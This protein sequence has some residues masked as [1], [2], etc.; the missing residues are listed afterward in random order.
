MKLC[1]ICQSK[2]PDDANFCP[3][4]SCA[5]AEG[6]RRL[7]A[8]PAPVAA[9]FQN[10]SK[11]GGGSTGEVWLA[12]DNESGIDVAY[13]LVATEALPTAATVAR[14]EREFKQLQRV[15]SPRIAAILDCGR[16]AEER[17]YVALELC[18]GDSL[19]RILKGGAVSLDKAKSI[20][21][22][23]GQALLEAQKAGIVHRDVAPKNVLVSSTGE[24]KVINFPLA[25]PLSDKIAGV[26]AYASPEQ[27]LGKPIDQRSNIY[28]LACVLYHLLTGEPPFQG[29]T[30]QSVLDLHVSSP[31]LPPSQR[32]PE[33]ALSPDVDRVLLK[34]L[35]KNSSQ[36][37]LTLR[38]F[39]TEVES[40][41]VAVP[42]TAAGGKDVGFARTMLF[43][44]GQAEVANMVAKA[45]ASRAGGGDA[46]SV[47]AAVTQAAKPATTAPSPE[48][49]HTPATVAVPLTAAPTAA[50]AA[51]RGAAAPADAS[52]G[53]LSRLTPPPVTPIRTEDAA[54]SAAA[55][56]AG[57]G[58]GAFRETLWFK[59]GDVEQMVAE[60]KAKLAAAGKIAEVDLPDDARPIEDRYVDDGSVT[61]EDRSKFSLRSG[62][63]ATALPTA[64]RSIP[65]EKMS[66]HD[67]IHEIA[68][69][70][71][72]LI[73]VV[74]GVVVAA[75]FVL[76]ITRMR[77]NKSPKH[78]AVPTAATVPAAV[79]P[80]IAP[81]SSPPAAPA[82]AAKP[83][84]TTATPST[85][86][87]K[88]EVEVVPIGDT[89]KKKSSSQKRDRR[90]RR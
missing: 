59:K 21:S 28:S 71:R 16:T 90:H 48:A 39:L 17:L 31:P 30:T 74:A 89:V 68:G 20:V 54:A 40:L 8:A 41:A 81:V 2:Y 86:T 12:K 46:A 73:L 57:P 15:G 87:P 44:G 47:T 67:V 88:P 26:P 55:G 49:A 76:A 79:A 60:A 33:A 72:T 25:K 14:A 69:A 62:G 6:P 18:Q 42:A 7:V 35:S 85:A 45:I 34:A 3:Q 83:V 10:V 52:S 24:V 11:L 13:K 77:S 64:G 5:T 23:V 58:K 82:I 84:P 22:Q 75:L 38:L 51:L 32:R 50:A 63:T 4:E 37:H 1:P 78:G 36:R 56:G 9:R 80:A 27:A 70:R 61:A 65:G 19:E 43:A 29:P 66:E 53:S